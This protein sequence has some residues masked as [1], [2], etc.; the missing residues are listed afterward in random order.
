[1]ALS[2][3]ST[4]CIYIRKASFEKLMREGLRGR[5]SSASGEIVKSYIGGTRGVMVIKIPTPTLL[6]MLLVW[7]DWHIHA[8]HCMYNTKIVH[9]FV[10]HFEGRVHG[11]GT[12]FGT[13]WHLV[14]QWLL[15]DGLASQTTVRVVAYSPCTMTHALYPQSLTCI[16]EIYR[17]K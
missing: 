9:L 17:K 2:M 14:W 15:W 13:Q 4:H 5:L 10:S 7:H 16:F 11:D 8:M 1:M 6:V 3:G 12:H